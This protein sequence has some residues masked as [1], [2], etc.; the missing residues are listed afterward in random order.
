MNAIKIESANSNWVFEV[1]F[2]SGAQNCWSVV[3]PHPVEAHHLTLRSTDE[4]EILAD[5]SLIVTSGSLERLMANI[6]D[7]IVRT[8]F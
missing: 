7:H 1:K 4:T 2:D 5:G 6:G 8:Q 3:F